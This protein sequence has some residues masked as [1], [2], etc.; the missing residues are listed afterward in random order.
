MW[1]YGFYYG[2]FRVVM[3]C[4]LSSCFFFSLLF[5]IVITSLGE[6]GAGLCASRPFVFYFARVNFSPFLLPLGVRDWL[7]FVIVALPGFFYQ[8]V[9]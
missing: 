6:E 4:S 7:R 8:F 1:L 2:A 9:Y 5:S 3:L